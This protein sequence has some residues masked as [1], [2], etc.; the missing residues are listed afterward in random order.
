MSQLHFQGRGFRL[1]GTPVSITPVSRCTLLRYIQLK[2]F[3]EYLR[4]L[5]SGKLGEQDEM[6]T[7]IYPTRFK[8]QKGKVYVECPCC[9]NEAEQ[10]WID[11]KGACIECLRK[12]KL[13]HHRSSESPRVLRKSL[14]QPSFGGIL[15]SLYRLFG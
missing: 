6:S 15:N 8:K 7:W 3:K 1:T 9:K 2:K 4:L 10:S 5:D 12:R 11:K 14:S 13:A